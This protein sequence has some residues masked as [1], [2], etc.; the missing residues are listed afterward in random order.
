MPKSVKSMSQDSPSP[1]E[2]PEEPSQEESTRTT[3]TSTHQQQELSP[4]SE[5]SHGHAPWTSHA[6]KPKVHASIPKRCMSTQIG[7]AKKV[8]GAKPDMEEP[9]VAQEKKFTVLYS[10]EP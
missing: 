8:S 1:R 5:V 2:E 9:E 10:L 3:T 6:A 7:S 4:N